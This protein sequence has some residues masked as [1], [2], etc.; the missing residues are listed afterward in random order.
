MINRLALSSTTQPDTYAWALEGNGI[1]HKHDASVY[2]FVQQQRTH[3]HSYNDFQLTS[4]DSHVTRRFDFPLHAA[5]IEAEAEAQQHDHHK[6]WKQGWREGDYW[7]P[8]CLCMRE[9]QLSMVLRPVVKR[10]K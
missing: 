10:A 7:L 9:Q 1:L 3:F 4:T 2:D 6:Q 5:G 8:E